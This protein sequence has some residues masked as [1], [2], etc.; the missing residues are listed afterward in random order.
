MLRRLMASVVLALTLALAAMAVPTAQ[1]G[2]PGAVPAPESM[3]GWAPC[4][5]YKLATYEVISDYFRKLDAASDRMQLFDIGKTVGG[6]P[7]QLV[8]IQADCA[9][10]RT[11]P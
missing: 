10:A 5:D 3:I 4:A 7:A 9:D 2:A 1:G 6:E 8:E 11:Q